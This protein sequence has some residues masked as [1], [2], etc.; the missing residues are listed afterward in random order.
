VLSASPVSRIEETSLGRALVL[1]VEADTTVLGSCDVSY[2]TCEVWL[3]SADSQIVSRSR[4]PLRSAPHTLHLFR[5]SRLPNRGVLSPGT[6]RLA[7]RRGSCAALSASAAAFSFAM[8]SDSTAASS[9]S[10]ESGMVSSEEMLGLRE[11]IEV[12]V[13]GTEEE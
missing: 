12:G 9:A 1:D 13:D 4:S 6:S 10:G 5:A 2:A 3:Q 11:R 7:R 8:R